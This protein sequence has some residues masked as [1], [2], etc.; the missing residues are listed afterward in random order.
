MNNLNTLLQQNRF[1]EIWTKYC[2]FL[3]LS[4]DEFIDIQE[5]LLLEQIELLGKS[6]MGRMLMGDVIPSS[7]DEF[8]DI[9]PL[10]TYADYLGY[11]DQKRED[12]LPRKPLM[13][14][15]T[16]GR[17]GEYTFKW[18]PYTRKMYDHLGVVTIASMILA[19]CTKKG[20]VNL[21]RNGK[22]L[23]AT[24]PPPYVSGLLSHSA[25]EQINIKYLPS[26][27]VGDAMDFRDRIRFGFTLAMREGLDFFYGIASVLVGIGEQF[28]KGSGRSGLSLEMLRPN[29]LTRMIKGFIK[30]KINNEPP[31]P[32]HFWKLTGIMTGGTDTSVYKKVVEEY[33]GRKP[34]EGY[35]ATE[36]GTMAVQAWNYEGL[37]FF[38]ETNFLEFIPE[39][40]LK[41]NQEDPEYQP[42]T[43]LY[44]E[45][46][47]GVYELVFT[48]FHG[49]IFTRYRV[50]DMFEVISKRDEELNIDLPQVKF[51]GRVND[52]IE[53]GAFAVITERDIW[54]SIEATGINY[55][56]WVARKVEQEGKTYMHLFI[57]LESSISLDAEE[58]RQ[59]VSDSLKTINTD[60]ADLEDMMDYQALK[61]SLLNPGSFG[62]YMDYQKSQGADLGHTKPPHMKPT[63]EQM[64][65]LLRDKKIK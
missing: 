6:V 58:V 4:I 1:E 36:G 34:L 39:A 51:Y 42:K 63:K 10:T 57:E 2:G 28:S 11:I 41:K 9:V 23:L 48:N 62:A 24:A 7:I 17:S 22:V 50:G 8:R 59:K 44:N 37:T 25:G 64:S 40:E 60:F 38:P 5:R 20:E 15:R 47:P 3:D 43:V 54:E 61:I 33:W 49:G 52:L 45:L 30:S 46:E 14:S 19:S 32:K 27:E 21:K 18:V 35:A 13:W 55:H 16:S 65:T 29:V 31:M 53:L 12:V 56:E 26:L